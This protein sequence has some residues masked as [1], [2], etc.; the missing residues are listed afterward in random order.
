MT[1]VVSWFDELLV[2]RSG[3]G[4]ADTWY[5]VDFAFVGHVGKCVGKRC[6]D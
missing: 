2:V 4:L 1:G 6:V 5:V 3:D